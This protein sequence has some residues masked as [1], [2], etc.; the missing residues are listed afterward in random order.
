MMAFR[1]FLEKFLSFLLSFACFISSLWRIKKNNFYLVFWFMHIGENVVCTVY[2]WKCFAVWVGR[3]ATWCQRGTCS[4]DMQAWVRR[5][6]GS[7]PRR[8]LLWAASLT[9]ALVCC[10][11]PSMGR[12]WPTN[13]KWNQELDSSQQSSANPP[14]KKCCSLNLDTPR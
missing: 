7:G 10:P 14:A 3:T 4:R 13:T 8:D 11:S 9:P 12:R 5:A 2:V 6:R 1:F